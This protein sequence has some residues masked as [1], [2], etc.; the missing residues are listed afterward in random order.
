MGRF[1]RVI[2]GRDRLPSRCIVYGGAYGPG[3]KEAVRRLFDDWTRLK[4]NWIRYAFAVRN[5]KEYLMV[6]NVYGGAVTLE[7]LNVLKD[8]GTE[9][10]FFIGSMY[11]KR[12]PVG[13]LVIPVLV[14]DYAGLVRVDTP[15]K[16]I[17]KPDGDSIDAVRSA[18][19]ASELPYEEAKVASVPCV[20]H[21][22]ARVRKLVADG[23]DI[24]GVEMEVSTFYHFSRKLG[25][26]GHALLYVS[27]N[28]MYGVISG[29]KAVWRAR[30]E[31]LQ[32]ATR[33]A[34]KVLGS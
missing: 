32:T 27:D 1:S 5:G 28:P 8:G 14:T 6:F 13:A 24:A 10:V 23:K 25:L 34:L 20:L 11:A 3:R 19:E 4:G 2:F 17:V 33:V 18:L 29:A 7:V 9:T 15:R 30:K 16:V 26:R 12:L 21:D 31:S 22:V